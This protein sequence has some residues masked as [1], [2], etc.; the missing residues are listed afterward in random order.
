MIPSQQKK[1]QTAHEKV[2][3]SRNSLKGNL[4][5]KFPLGKLSESLDFIALKFSGKAE[6]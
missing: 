2:N 4:S 1:V 3:A 6:K 5:L